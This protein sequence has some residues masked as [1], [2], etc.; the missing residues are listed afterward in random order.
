MSPLLSTALP[1]FMT[2]EHRFLA[3]FTTTSLIGE[4]NE[5]QYF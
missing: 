2:A 1:K 5:A 3:G 4:A